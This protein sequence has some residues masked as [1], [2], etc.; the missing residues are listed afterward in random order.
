[1]NRERLW[2]RQHGESE[3]RLATPI[4]KFLDDQAN[5]LARE[6]EQHGYPTPGIAEQIIHQQ[7]E[8][9]KLLQAVHGPLLTQMALGA[10]LELESAPPQKSFRLERS[11][12]PDGI[13]SEFDI[14]APIM[15]SIQVALD[16]LERQPYW[17]A[18]QQ[19]TAERLAKIIGDCIANGDPLRDVVSKVRSGLGGTAASSRAKAIARTETTGALNAGHYAARSELISEGL[20]KGSEWLG[21]QDERQRAA[22]AANDGKVVAAG[23]M[24]NVGGEQAPYP[25]YWGLSAAQRVNCRCTTVAAGTF[26][27]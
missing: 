6:I 14:P 5:R 19:T 25:G 9:A 18:I 26:A 22:H 8:N 23:E 10:H 2:L 3:R 7:T 20:V 15:R 13:L 16:D 4:K 17:L 27:D 12:L 24:F 11:N 1:M 21:V